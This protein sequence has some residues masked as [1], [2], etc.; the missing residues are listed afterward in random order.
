MIGVAPKSEANYRNSKHLDLI[1]AP[2]AWEETMG[3]GVEIALLDSGVDD[4]HPDLI[5]NISGCMDLTNTTIE[6][7]TGH[8]THCA[9]VMVAAYTSDGIT[10]VAPEARV[11][12]YKVI[13]H[14]NEGHIEEVN[15]A[16]R[17]AIDRDVDIINMSLG[18]V[19]HPGAEMELLIMEAYEKGIVMIAASGN[20]N[21]R[22]LYPARFD[23]VIAVS[24]V[25][26]M[27]HRAK[28]SN[29]GIENEVCAPATNI[30]STY[31]NRK[32]ALLSGT[33]MAAPMVSGACALYISVLKESFDKS[34]VQKYLLHDIKS[35]SKDLGIDGKD[36]EFG[37]GILDTGKFVSNAVERKLKDSSKSM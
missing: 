20:Q 22:V 2:I 30:A 12:S 11:Y 3:Q 18:L 37:W 21:S 1:N 8:G 14:E 25:D 6:D 19:R 7:L 4:T 24:G 9:G 28:F 23:Q 10:G 36:E 35:S 16:L 32:Y 5:D 27:L 17:H 26:Q 15:R 33:S 31:K 29:Y 13:G 34:M